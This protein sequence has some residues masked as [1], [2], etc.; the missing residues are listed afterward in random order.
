MIERRRFTLAVLGGA[1]LV[2]VGGCEKQNQSK[3]NVKVTVEVDTPA[4]GQT[5]SSVYEVSAADRKALLPDEAD[6]KWSTRGE[7][8]VVDLPNGRRLFA[9]MRTGAIHGDI[10]SMVL[11]TLDA[12]FANSMVQ[13]TNKLSNIKAEGD[14]VTVAPKNYPMLVMFKDIKDPTTVKQVDPTNL[15]PHFGVGYRIKTITAQVVQNDVTSVLDTHLDSSFWKRWGSVHKV[16]M[17]RNGGVVQNSY[18]QSLAGN[19]S[20]NDFTTEK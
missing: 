5:G 14:L 17:T 6:R 3:F 9:L 18:F 4:G 13:S 7:A 8:V 15:V 16:Q 19:L 1:A 12:E 11:A 10:A 20:R 2:A